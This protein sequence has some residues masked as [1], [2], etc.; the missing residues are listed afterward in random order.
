M[1]NWAFEDILHL[2]L[3]NLL[4]KKSFQIVIIIFLE[5]MTEL[6]AGVKLK[7][8]FQM[9]CEFSIQV[10]S[11][12]TKKNFCELPKI[13]KYFGPCTLETLFL[14]LKKLIIRLPTFFLFG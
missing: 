14:L 6:I 7:Q 2:F 1:G 5:V 13:V 11:V 9:H 4:F 8:N 12:L 10:L 3:S